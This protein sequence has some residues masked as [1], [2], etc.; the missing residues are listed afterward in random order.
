M[1]NT[2][3]F[4][5]IRDLHNQGHNISQISRK[6]GYNRRT[7]RRH[8]AADTMPQ[9]QN[10]APKSSKLD[11]FKD[12]IRDRINAY[13]LSAKRIY[14]EIQ[15]M[16]FSGKYTIVKDFIHQIR[17]SDTLLAVYRFET[18]PGKQT[19]I[20]WGECGHI[21]ADKGRRKLYC[22]SAILG[23]SRMRYLEFTL[24]TDVH[25]LIQCHI[26]A[27]NYFGGYTDEFLYDNMKTVI[28]K[29]AIKLSDYTWNTKFEDFFRHL[30]FIPR[31]CKP[32]SPQ[33]KGKVENSIK[34]M[35]KD[36]LLGTVVT[37]LADMNQRL[38][39]WCNR[40][41][42]EI[43]GTT[44]EIP[45]ERLKEENLKSFSSI[46]PYINRIA[47]NR[48][49]SRDSYVTYAG[50]KYSVPFLYAG[51][52]SVIELEDSLLT[53]KVNGEVICIHEI[54]SGSGRI[55]REKEHFKGLLSKRKA[56]NTDNMNL[57]KKYKPL[58][59]MAHP[60]VEKRPLSVYDSC[61]GTVSP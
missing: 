43:H 51:R 54:S 49:I 23:Y 28:I 50:N 5:M 17:P 24:S 15:D 30:G 46:T 40:V 53:V 11:P 34:Y 12:Y 45:F 14:R 47:E 59:Q 58:F 3:G 60:E 56:C 39:Q 37:H 33:T 6:T 20:D 44:H 16:G 57:A 38:L 36:F 18:E 48:Q 25:T 35:K 26:N 1:V 4:Y 42:S 10:R 32:Y 8:L 27:F 19:Q 7:V 41:N 22:F 9:K 21:D 52:E 61:A 29:R 55:I 2:E 13:P 31:V